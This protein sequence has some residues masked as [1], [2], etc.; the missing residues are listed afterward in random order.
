MARA[1]TLLL[2]GFA[3]CVLSFVAAAASEPCKACSSDT[4]LTLGE[5][6]KADRAF[7]VGR[8]SKESAG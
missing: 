3:A 4:G 6:I 8:V 7:D 1:L 5:E 2:L